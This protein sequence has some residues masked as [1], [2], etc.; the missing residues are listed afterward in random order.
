M[1]SRNRI[2]E[3]AFKLTQLIGVVTLRALQILPQ[4]DLVIELMDVLLIHQELLYFLEGLN[5]LSESRLQEYF[6]HIL[7][8]RQQVMNLKNNMEKEKNA[9]KKRV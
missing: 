2:D 6:D 8:Y 7:E 1:E 5:E 4:S 9:T 3:S